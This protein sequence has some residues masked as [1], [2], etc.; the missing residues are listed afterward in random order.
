MAS[1]SV[2]HPL[3]PLLKSELRAYMSHEHK[4]AFEGSEEDW[5]T[6][7][8]S[9]H[10]T[11]AGVRVGSTEAKR[12]P[13]V[14]FTWS[15]DPSNAVP[16]CRRNEVRLELMPLMERLCGGASNAAR[17]LMALSEQ[18]WDLRKN[19]EADALCYLSTVVPTLFEEPSTANASTAPTHSHN[20]RV[21]PPLLLRLPVTP[22]FFAL[23]RLARCEV[24]YMTLTEAMRR[25]GVSSDSLRQKHIHRVLNLCGDTFPRGKVK[26]GTGNGD[27]GIVRL[28]GDMCVRFTCTQVAEASNKRM[29]TDLCVECNIEIYVQKLERR[30]RASVVL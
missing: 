17:R 11:T 21:L 7:V 10:L 12:R 19:V 25:H 1:V 18:S 9:P 14:Q 8:A 30:R 23:G 27:R 22:A 5:R 26:G 16:G 20:D 15:E 13:V 29:I 3:L 28:A 24:V 4:L 2:L 6:L